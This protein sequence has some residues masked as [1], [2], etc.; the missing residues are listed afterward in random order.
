M[1]TEKEKTFPLEEPIQLGK[2][3]FSEITLKRPNAGEI[4]NL[5]HSLQKHGVPA[6]GVVSFI[7]TQLKV[8]PVDVRKLDG[9]VFLEI[10][11]WVTGFLMSSQKNS[12]G[13]SQR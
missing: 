7:G 8:P 4:E 13:S 3:T 6:P 11:D 1:S 5:Q 9:E 12:E 10:Q 2:E